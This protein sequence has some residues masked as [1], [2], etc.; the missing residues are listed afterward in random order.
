MNKK[1]MEENINMGSATKYHSANQTMV[2][3]SSNKPWGNITQY[4][5]KEF[6]VSTGQAFYNLN[7]SIMKGEFK[8]S[9]N[10]NN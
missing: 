3:N 5:P 7:K 9:D 1:G 6:G 8:L 2:N 4:K 10:P